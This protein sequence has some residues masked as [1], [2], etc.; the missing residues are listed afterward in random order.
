MISFA[1]DH[2]NDLLIKTNFLLMKIPVKFLEQSVFLLTSV[3]Y[4]HMTNAS[5]CKKQK[6]LPYN[7]I[8]FLV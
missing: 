6:N 4:Y 7:V 2:F 1:K 5:F 8:Y 3:H